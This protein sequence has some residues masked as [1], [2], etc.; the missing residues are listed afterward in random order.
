MAKDQPEKA[1]ELLNS[2][3]DKPD[4]RP[5]DRNMRIRLVAEKIEQL[6]RRMTKPAQKPI[7]A[8]FN[9][10]AE[11]LYRTYANQNAS[12]EWVL[13]AFFG[14][15]QRIDE[16]LDVL[17][18]TWNSN[19]PVVL[20]QVC[21]ILVRNSKIDNEQMRRLDHILRSAQKKFDHA[22]PLLMVTADLYTRQAR[23][24]EA[25]NLY[26]EIL[27]KNSGHSVAMNN[28]A[29]LLALQ[30]V[31]LDEALK[32][33][34]QAIEISGPMAA[35]LDSRASVYIARNEPEKALAD[36]TEALTEAE[37]PER[38]FHQAQAYDE[39]GQANA[40][41]EAMQKA[42]KEGLVKEMLQPLEIP[43]FEKLRKLVK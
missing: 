17:E 10:Q 11:L 6:A 43:A 22:V 38:L 16:A 29:V 15:Q 24:A 23:Y 26:R 39:A 34:N 40:A 18:K 1:L 13:A 3:L 14:R 9:Q 42:M 2:Y 20:A 37:T 30:G 25:E 41:A 5:A 4:A 33:I 35:M 36:M 27:Q 21:A 8:R 7:V 12:Q 32:L 19:N 31:K 28:L